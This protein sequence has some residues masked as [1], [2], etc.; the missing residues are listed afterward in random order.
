MTII[1]LIKMINWCG[2]SA[3]LIETNKKIN[4][5]FINLP[6]I[7]KEGNRIVK[8]HFDKQHIYLDSGYWFTPAIKVHGREHLKQLLYELNNR[9]KYTA[10]QD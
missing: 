9:Q 5:C 3:N 8:I 1:K 6:P 10:T 4:S 7:T 2:Y